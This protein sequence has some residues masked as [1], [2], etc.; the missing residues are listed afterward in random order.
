MLNGMIYTVIE[1]VQKEVDHLF[2]ITSRLQTNQ[3]RHEHNIDVNKQNI[4][5]LNK[6]LS[7]SMDV[8]VFNDDF[9]ENIEE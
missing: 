1:K 2:K 6:M 3:K 9:A 4:D 8:P 5:R 7:L